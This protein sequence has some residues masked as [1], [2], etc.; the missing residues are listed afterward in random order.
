MS[1]KSTNKAVDHQ[2]EHPDDP[3]FPLD[4]SQIK[5]LV[6]KMNKESIGSDR[7]EYDEV[8]ES[9]CGT[10]DDSQPVEQYDGSL[11]VTQAFV[12]NNQS[13]VGVLRWHSNLAD[14][15][16]NPGNVA[17]QRWCTGTLITNNL[18]LT[19]GHCFDQT[20]GTWRRPRVNG[21]TNIISPQEIATRMNV[22]FDYQVNS[23]GTLK[24]PVSVGIEEL[25]EY[26]LDGLDFAIVRLAGSPGTQFGTT[27]LAPDDGNVGDMLCIIGHPAGQPKRIEAGPLT[28]FD[29]HRVRYNDIDT[30]G[31]NSGSGILR[32]SDGCIVGVHTNGGCNEAMTGSNFGVRISRVR[33]ASP[34]IQGLSAHTN[35]IRDQLQ[36]DVASDQL[37]SIQDDVHKNIRDDIATAVVPDRMT[38]ILADRIPTNFQ[39]DVVT[40]FV[41][42]KRP[43][44]PRDDHFTGFLADKRPT[45]TVL[46]RGPTHVIRDQSPTSILRD[47]GPTNFIKDQRPTTILNDR[48]P[49]NLLEDTGGTHPVGDRKTTGLDKQF[50]DRLKTDPLRGRINP[51]NRGEQPFVLATPHHASGSMAGLAQTPGAGAGDVDQYLDEL[52]MAYEELQAQAEE[53]AAQMEYIEMEFDEIAVEFGY[54]DE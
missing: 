43:T 8:R 23:A 10:T 36:T 49:T 4:F 25:I 44:T 48:G 19:A 7:L 45:T 31:G 53:I 42:D 17:G 16:T 12:N 15:Y 27:G 51:L 47:V 37:T 52:Q 41:A 46:D 38:A 50:S 2:Q 35:R 18:F 11:G 21:T 54:M 33:D 14:V 24:T 30:L 13:A 6:D 3:V 1:K 29:A 34:T 5:R 20:G 39:D 28:S 40:H 22:E 26:R 9:I 32:A